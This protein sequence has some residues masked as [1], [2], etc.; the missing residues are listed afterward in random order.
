MI[1]EAQLL[2]PVAVHFN[3]RTDGRRCDTDWDAI[4]SFLATTHTAYVNIHLNVYAQDMPLIP[5]DDAPTPAQQEQVIARMLADVQALTDHFGSQRVIAE[6]VPFRPG[7]NHN[8]RA[9]VEPQAICT[10][11]EETQCGLL[12]D[13]SHARISA[14]AL[15]MDAQAYMAALPA[16]RLKELHFTGLHHWGDHLQDHLAILEADWPWL[17]WT[18][19]NITAE[20]WGQAHLLAFEYGGTGEFF[21]RFSDPEVIREQVPRLYRLCHAANP[22]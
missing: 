12:L 8:L 1:A 16:K 22:L 20:R 15:G 17:D 21:G 13:I 19:E 7:A 10:V 5:P 6:N 2:R 3:L 11:L 4:E 9:C 14:A 18:L